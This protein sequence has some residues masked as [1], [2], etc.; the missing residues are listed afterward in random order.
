MHDKKTGTNCLTLLA[1]RSACKH[2]EFIARICSIFTSDCLNDLLIRK[3]S[4]IIN[5]LCYDEHNLNMFINQLRSLIEGFCADIVRQ[6]NETIAQITPL[7]R[8][9]EHFQTDFREKLLLLVSLIKGEK[10]IQSIF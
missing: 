3:L 7:D 4:V 8:N 9:S 5:Q 6:V 10:K 2:E 1:K